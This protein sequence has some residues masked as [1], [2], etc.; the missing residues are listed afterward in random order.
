MSGGVGGVTG[1]IP[2]PPPDPSVFP[3]G[4]RE[5]GNVCPQTSAVAVE[6]VLVIHQYS[7]IHPIESKI[8]RIFDSLASM[9]S[10]RAN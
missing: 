10:Q 9:L 3:R 1:E 5:V 4:S 8:S 2:S 7:Q 6:R